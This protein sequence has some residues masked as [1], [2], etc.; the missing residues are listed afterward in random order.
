MARAATTSD[1]F[2][3]VA[4]PRRRAI[5]DFLVDGDGH[6]VSDLV[7]A[8]GLGQPVVSKHLRVLRD[9]GLVTAQR[10]GRWKLYSVNGQKLKAVHDWTRTYE[11]FWNH[12]LNCLKARAEQKAKRLAC[13]DQHA[14]PQGEH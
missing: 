9:V 10:S 8:L 7:E 12:Q 6:P 11:R 2:N 3:A 5:L 4:E 13:K 1:V 14:K